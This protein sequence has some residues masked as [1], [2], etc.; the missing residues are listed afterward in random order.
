MKAVIQRVRHACVE[1]D[2]RKTGEIG[3]GLLVLLGVEPGDT[4]QTARLWRAKR[5][6]CAFLQTTRTR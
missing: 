4:E 6:R 5:R 3:Q 2:G 1:V